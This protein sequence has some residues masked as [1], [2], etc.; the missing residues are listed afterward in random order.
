[1]KNGF[2]RVGSFTPDIKVA[3]CKYNSEQIINYM[4][5]AANA[6]CDIVVFPELSVTGYTCGDLFFQNT[7]INSAKEEI[8]N[9]KNSSAG[10]DC[11]F[12]V[13]FPLKFK[14]NLY[15]VAAVISNGEI[16]GIVP[17][18]FN[19]CY[20]EFSD[21]RYFTDYSNKEQEYIS[22]GDSVIPFGDMIFTFANEEFNVSFAAQVGEE[23]FNNTSIKKKYAE[24][25][26]TII[27]NMA[28]RAHV[29]GATEYVESM[30]K[31]SSS[32][33]CCANVYCEAG[34]G[35]STT[36]CVFAGK[37]FIYENSKLIASEKPFS[38]NKMLIADIDVDLLLSER[39]FTSFKNNNNAFNVLLPAYVKNKE[40]IL[41][42][43]DKLPF[44]PEKDMTKRCEEILAIQAH[45]LKK[46]LIHTNCKSA[47]V[48]LSGG[49]D[50]TLA[51]IATVEA[52]DL[53]GIDRKNI[54]CITMPCFGT[55]NRTYNNACKLCDEFG[56][57]LTEIDIKEAVLCH[58]KDINQ[59]VN[60]H[61]V[62]YENSQARERTQILMDLANQK[63]GL[64]VGTGDLSEVALGWATYNGDHMSMYGING[65]IS[66]TLVRYMV[67]YYADKKGGVLKE[68]LY[69]IL[70]TPVS[71]EL[72]PPEDGKISQKT[73]DI[74]GP[75]ELHDFFLYHFKRYGF[76][77]NKIF[78][79]AKHTFKDDYSEEIIS[80]WLKIFLRR[81]ITQQFK[82]SCM[83]DGVKVGSV[84]LSPRG[85][86][87]MPSDADFSIW[88]ESFEF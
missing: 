14:N 7:L 60:N 20:G 31:A 2:V 41:R 69:D 80:K 44:A 74:V 1:M 85:E 24:D 70:D 19:P 61:D 37:K 6:N 78:T 50:S 25:G 45:A 33:C 10:I 54:D 56:C 3:N 40:D 42:K 11:V 77:P 87:K 13:G 34:D 86:L 9:I 35:E 36:D 48:G 82:R 73:E 83:P 21:G 32:E 68:V 55:S 65:D 27:L 28:A 23:V 38:N 51:L 29:I 18:H 58:F 64:V 72:L 57:K 79:I 4:K 15:N 49:L 75:Y 62:T 59:D 88:L 53:A 47:V 30:L 71:P 84:A 52:F 63:N 22:F 43:Y 5:E 39:A 76:T 67:K 16:Y 46:R 81:F 8:I 26:A 12:I 66:K 17:A